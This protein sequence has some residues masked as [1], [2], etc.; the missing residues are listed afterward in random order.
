MNDSQEKKFFDHV[1][2]IVISLVLMCMMLF[3]LTVFTVALAAPFVLAYW[4]LDTFPML[5]VQAIYI[6]LV[7]AAYSQIAQ[8]WNKDSYRDKL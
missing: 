2:D 7:L 3:V 5:V 6:I 1:T 4:Y 8:N